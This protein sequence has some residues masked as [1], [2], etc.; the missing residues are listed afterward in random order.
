[1]EAA[2]DD[3]ESGGIVARLFDG[4]PALPG[5]LPQMRLLAALHE[6][7]LARR[8]PELAAF[9]PS[10]GGD[11]P[12]QEAWPAARA[13]LADNAGWIADRLGRTMQTNEPGRS[14]VLYAVLLWLSARHRRPVR[15]LEIGASAGLNLL[16]DRYAYEIDSTVLGDPDAALRFAQPW[17]PAPPG[18]LAAAARVLRI[19]HREGC[20]P[21][22]LDPSNPD[23]RRRL[24]SY[25]WPDEPDRL[26]RLD[27]ALAIA[28]PAPPMVV[29]AP[30]A[31][32]LADAL[33]RR[34]AGE[35]TVVWHSVMR[36]YVDPDEWASLGERFAEAVRAAPDR[37][38]VWVG[39]EPGEDHVAGFVVSVS[40]DPVRD[41]VP[42]ATCGDHGPPVRWDAS[43]QP[44]G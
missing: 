39:M 22:P 19:T 5:S 6:L 44:I 2:A 32:W 34:R 17:Q 25:I 23:D 18:D 13:A 40:E 3:I 15:L 26:R 7:V 11:R 42:V 12:P 27:A 14:A 21:H 20:D 43:H 28:A 24:R 38:V 16:A 29:R 35:L 10:A 30:A 31:E 33:E 8:V 37:P 41:P 9:Y 36:Q 1:M 4:D